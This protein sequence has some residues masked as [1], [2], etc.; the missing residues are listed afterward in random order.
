[1]N[2][3]KKS[4]GSIVL[5]LNKVVSDLENFEQESGN[6][7]DI[8]SEEKESLYKKEEEITKDLVLARKIKENMSKLLGK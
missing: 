2:I 3:K 7:L 1:M 4:L 6:K 8:I 5:G